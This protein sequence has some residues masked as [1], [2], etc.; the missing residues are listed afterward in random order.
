MKSDDRVKLRNRIMNMLFNTLDDRKELVKTLNKI[1]REYKDYTVILKPEPLYIYGMLYEDSAILIKENGRR[2]AVIYKDKENGKLMIDVSSYDLMT[3]DE[4][5]EETEAE[6]RA[7]AKMNAWS[8]GYRDNYFEDD[9][10]ER[11]L[12]ALE[13]MGRESY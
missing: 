12:W 9:W 7:E 3:D 6:Q 2:F 1:Q 10:R 8:L 11:E 13:E 5:R 4:I